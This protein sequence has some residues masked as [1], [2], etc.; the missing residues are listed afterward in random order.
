MGDFDGI[1]TAE[2]KALH[3]DAIDAL[4]EDTALTLPCRLYY[5][6]TKWTDCPNCDMS[7]TSGM[8][9]N[10]YTSGGPVPF[11]NGQICPYCNGRGRTED[12]QTEDVYLGIIW[13]MKQWLKLGAIGS[14]AASASTNTG[15]SYIQTVSKFSTTYEKIRQAKE[16]VVDTDI[17]ANVH[18]RYV[19][20][21]EPKPGGFGADNYVVTIWQR[22]G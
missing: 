14:L 3:K 2:F 4:L 8:S 13:D 21:G 22:D 9:T 17:A 1:I 19:R 7:P 18:L 10:R 12:E 20:Y 11:P 16:L 15:E 5:G 6:N